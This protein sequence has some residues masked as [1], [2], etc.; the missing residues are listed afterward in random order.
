MGSGKVR[1]KN[2]VLEPRELRIVSSRVSVNSVS[3]EN[4]R[5]SSWSSVNTPAAVYQMKC[6]LV[7]LGS[8][9]CRSLTKGSLLVT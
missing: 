8:W 3:T 9:P 7:T 2:K 4:K 1:M 5:S 6:S